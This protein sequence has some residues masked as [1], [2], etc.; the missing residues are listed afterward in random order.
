MSECN[1][2][3]Q[4]NPNCKKWPSETKTRMVKIS[5]IREEF[6]GNK[7]FF[8]D[9]RMDFEP[10]QF[11]MVWLPGVDEKPIALIPWGK[12]FAVNIEGKGNSTKKMIEQKEG[13]KLGI[14]GPYGK[15][16]TVNGIK[17]AVIVAGGVGID[18]IV[19]LAQRLFESKCKTKIILGGRNKE[20]IV[21]EKELKKFGEVLVA[22]DDGSYGEKGFNVQILERLLSKGKFDLVYA[23]G[24][25]MMTVKALEIC[26]KHKQ[27]FEGSLERYMKCGIGICGECVIDD[28]LVCRDGPVFS[29]TELRNFKELG[30]QAYL[31][32]GKRV[33]LKEYYEWREE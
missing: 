15:P 5:K 31:K 32:S 10:G 11:A 27:A 1:C 13:D 6:S 8:M 3:G 4:G 19:M 28:K 7:T 18:S 24:P 21:F 25:E 16:F 12:K 26:I 33:S 9:E 30:K 17:K 29:G 2:K 20:R 23:C 22:T 14:R